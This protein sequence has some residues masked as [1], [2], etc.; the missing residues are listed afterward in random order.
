MVIGGCYKVVLVTVSTHLLSEKRKAFECNTIRTF[1][2]P[3]PENQDVPTS[4]SLREETNG[5]V[6]RK[7]LA[8]AKFGFGE[9]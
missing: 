5:T 7:I 6:P 9:S 4:H 1:L 2:K 8:Y 3:G